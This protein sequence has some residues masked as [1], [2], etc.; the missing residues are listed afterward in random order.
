MGEPFHVGS[1]QLGTA[2]GPL[3]GPWLGDLAQDMQEPESSERRRTG[4]RSLKTRDSPLPG[5]VALSRTAERLGLDKQQGHQA[6][7]LSPGLGPHRVS[8]TLSGMG[9]T[10]GV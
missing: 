8:L 10:P 6:G 4:S 5:E 3:R 9:T 1:G 7:G 2:S